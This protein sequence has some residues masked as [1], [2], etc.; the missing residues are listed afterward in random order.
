MF[1]VGANIGKYTEEIQEVL[2]KKHPCQIHAYEPNPIVFQTLKRRLGA[3]KRVTLNN[4]GVGRKTDILSFYYRKNSLSDT[5]GSFRSNAGN[6][7]GLREH[8]LVPILTIDDEVK[9]IATIGGEDPAILLVKIDVEGLEQSVKE[10]MSQLLSRQY[11]SAVYWERKG[12]ITEPTFKHEVQWLSKFGYYSYIL[13]CR[14]KSKHSC[15]LTLIRVD[16]P[17]YSDVFDPS[18]YRSEPN[19]RAKAKGRLG[20][21]MTMNLLSV[22]CRHPFVSFAAKTLSV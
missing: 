1:D 16:G 8:T 7:T 22:K 3:N 2:P 15:R 11:V 20:K 17:L 19:E 6:M 10:G 12:T 13:G 5:G 21:F 14:G 4:A 18:R 9:K